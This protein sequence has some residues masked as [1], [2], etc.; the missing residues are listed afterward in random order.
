[1]QRKSGLMLHISSLPNKFGFG[2]FSKEAYE[3]I[4]FLKKSGQHYWQ[5]LPVNPTNNSGSPF[6]CYS[7]FAGNPNLIDLTEFLTEKELLK[8]N[9][10]PT[11]EINFKELTETRINALKFIFNRDYEKYDLEEFKKQN[12]FWLQDYATFMAL[13]DF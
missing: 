3:F 13:K 8:L 12:S 11:T 1:M 2:C 7:V 10:K 5:V 9:I 6:Q 4:D